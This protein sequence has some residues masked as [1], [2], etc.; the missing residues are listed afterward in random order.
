VGN[1]RKELTGEKRNDKIEKKAQEVEK[2][3]VII[4]RCPDCESLAIVK[5]GYG[6]KGQQR[7][8]C[9]NKECRTTIFQL[10]YPKKGCERGIE[11]KIIKMAANANGVMDTARN[12]EISKYKVISTLKKQNHTYKT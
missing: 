10:E 12:L 11:R 2:M 7:Y 3:C 6:K 9:K 8:K 5:Y 1:G 4:V